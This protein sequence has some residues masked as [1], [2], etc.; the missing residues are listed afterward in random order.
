MKHNDLR[1]SQTDEVEAVEE[2]ELTD[3]FPYMLIVASMAVITIMH[4][5]L[6][7]LA[8]DFARY[9]SSH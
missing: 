2:V 5:I 6:Y 4:L 8:Q 9:F 1:L 3:S 7:P